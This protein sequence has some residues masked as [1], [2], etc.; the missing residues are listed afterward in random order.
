MKD[1]DIKQIIQ[2][3]EDLLMEQKLKNIKAGAEVQGDDDKDYQL[4]TEEKY[5][6]FV[7]KRNERNN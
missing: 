2:N 5:Q 6:E 1:N 4:G 3:L 7:R